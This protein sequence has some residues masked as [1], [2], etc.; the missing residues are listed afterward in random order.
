MRVHIAPVEDF[1]A[2]GAEWRALEA[3]LP[4][5]SVF[6]SWTW[7]GCLA[8]ER[9]TDPVLLRAEGGGRTRGLALFN[10]ARGRLCLAE[11]GDAALDAPFIEHNAPLAH[12]DAVAPL[13]RAAW[14]VPGARRLVLGGVAPEVL[15]AAGGTAWR[16]QERLAP[17]LDLAALRAAGGDAL[18][19]CSANTRQ[20][21]RRSQR[22]YAARGA[23]RLEAATTPARALEFFDAMLPLHEATWQSRGKPG[24]FATPFLQRFHRAL[25]AEGTARGEARMLRITA[26]GADVGVLYNLRRGGRICAY[27]SGFDHAGAARHEKPG[28]TSHALAIED[29]MGAGEQVYDFLAGADRYKLSLASG[30]APLWWAEL[31]RPWSVPG[32]AARLRA[33]LTKG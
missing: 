12:A 24:A 20:Q 1:A 25:I 15:A 21:V 8:A 19:A 11:S 14:D 5:A 17:F 31:V 28:L 6:Q 27:Q 2:L 18:G 30:T 29:A 13:L 4:R 10:R 26:G 33:R 3:E 7:V 23:L 32:L 9:F 22:T 16:R